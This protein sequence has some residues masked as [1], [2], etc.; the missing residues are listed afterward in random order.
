MPEL[1]V[2]AKRREGLIYMQKI[3]P[4][5]E[6]LAR[7]QLFRQRVEDALGGAVDWE[8]VTAPGEWC[9]TEVVCHLRDVEREVHQSRFR[10]LMAKDGAFLPGAVADEW[11]ASRGYREQDG[12]R[13]LAQFLSARLE[14]IDLLPDRADPLWQRQGQH[15]FFGPTTMHELL[16]LV[17][18]HD[19]AHWEQIQELLGV[20]QQSG[21]SRI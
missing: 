13:A 9:L 5:E 3:L 8:C 2:T 18:E 20:G 14:T 19:Q 7:L 1:D 12:A 4:V 21:K 17:V 6:L 10:A 15:A 16:H 11:V